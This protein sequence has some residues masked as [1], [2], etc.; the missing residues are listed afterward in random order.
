MAFA[1]QSPYAL[2]PDGPGHRA[3]EEPVVR[4]PGADASGVLQ[5]MRDRA[6]GAR[7]LG[8]AGPECCVASARG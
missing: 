2:L 5:P 4:Y 3:V 7:A 6:A 8:F 1:P